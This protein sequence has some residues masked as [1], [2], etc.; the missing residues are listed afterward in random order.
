[1]EVNFRYI[2]LFRKKIIIKV[3]GKMVYKMEKEFH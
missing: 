2:K 3:N 1:M